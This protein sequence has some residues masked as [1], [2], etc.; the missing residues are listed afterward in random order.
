MPNVAGVACAFRQPAANNVGVKIVFVPVGGGSTQHLRNVEFKFI[1]RIFIVDV[2]AHACPWFAFRQDHEETDGPT[3][4]NIATH[5]PIR[6]RIPSNADATSLTASG[7]WRKEAA[8]PN[9]DIYSSG[10]EGLG[11]CWPLQN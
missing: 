3:G 7:L 6:V 8:G 2:P 9:G 5:R 1:C 10:P 11:N 4:E